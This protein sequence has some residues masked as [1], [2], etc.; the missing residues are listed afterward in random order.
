MNAAAEAR[1]A[2]HSKA[3]AWREDHN[4]KIGIEHVCHGPKRFGEHRLNSC[5]E[6]A[7]VAKRGK[8]K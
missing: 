7:Q 2:T 6:L 5:E 3:S 8:G 4:R 1:A